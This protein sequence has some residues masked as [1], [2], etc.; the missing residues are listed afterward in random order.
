MFKNVASVKQ[1]RAKPKTD[2]QTGQISRLIS[3]SVLL[4]S[5]LFHIY[6]RQKYIYL[7]PIRYAGGHFRYLTD[8]SH[9][10]AVLNYAFLFFGARFEDPK[11]SQFASWLQGTIVAPTSAV[12]FGNFYFVYSFN[13]NVVGLRPLW[14]AHVQHAGVLFASLLEAYNFPHAQFWK[15]KKPGQ[16]LSAVYSFWI[17]SIYNVTGRWPYPYFPKTS[18]FLV[19]YFIVAAAGAT[20]SVLYF[21]IFIFFEKI[22]SKLKLKMTFGIKL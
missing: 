21:K 3:F 1:F 12:V 10:I 13:K 19:N 20:F 15:D 9:Q 4:F 7:E 22:L 2:F 17:A 5:W 16:I 11:L 8:I 18:S 14:L 6:N